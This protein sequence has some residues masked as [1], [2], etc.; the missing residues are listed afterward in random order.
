MKT[1]EREPRRKATNS[2]LVEADGAARRI[3]RVAQRGAC[4]CRAVELQGLPGP[5]P[6]TPEPFKFLQRAVESDSLAGA[7]IPQ[8]GSWAFSK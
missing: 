1:W 4:R 7:Q 6:A 5:I 8:P 2:H 3:H